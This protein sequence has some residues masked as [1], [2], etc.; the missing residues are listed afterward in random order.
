MKKKQ[1]FEG[2]LSETVSFIPTTK[3][4]SSVCCSNVLRKFRLRAVVSHSVRSNTN[5]FSLGYTSTHILHTTHTSTYTYRMCLHEAIDFNLQQNMY[6]KDR[7]RVWNRAYFIRSYSYLTSQR[8]WGTVPQFY[9]QS[10][11]LAFEFIFM[12]GYSGCWLV[13]LFY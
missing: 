10:Y 2:R 12:D 4:S 11:T 1:S 8:E 7:S 6:M 13:R 9:T 5:K 3:N